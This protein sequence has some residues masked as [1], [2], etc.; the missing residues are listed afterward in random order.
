MLRYIGNNPPIGTRPE[1][2]TYVVQN[3]TG[4]TVAVGDLV[5]LDFGTS[6]GGATTF[7]P[8]VNTS[9]WAVAVDPNHTSGTLSTTH[10]YTIAY[11]T[12][13]VTDLL[14]NAGADGKNVKVELGLVTQ[15]K[16][17]DGAAVTYS[18][19]D[20]LYADT[21][22]SGSNRRLLKAG[23]T[24]A[25]ILAQPLIAVYQD[26]DAG[27]SPTNILRRVWIPGWPLG[28]PTPLTAN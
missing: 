2:Y 10:R 15:A 28:F 18:A 8:G 16:C 14:G 7:L 9:T 21:A 22:S 23:S 4:A 19:G 6:S 5:M 26:A 24:T 11:P 1:N 3:E 25:M 13:V 20:M 27:S 12:G 17:G